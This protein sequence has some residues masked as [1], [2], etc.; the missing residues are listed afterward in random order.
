MAKRDAANSFAAMLEGLTLE[1]IRELGAR[2]IDLN[3]FDRRPRPVSRRRPRQRSPKTLT[4]RVDLV[5]ATPPIWRRVQVPSTLRLDQVHDLAQALFGWTDSH[6]HRFALGDSVWGGEAELFL[7]PY[8]VD[9]GED[10]GVPASSVRL[11]ETLAEVGDRLRYV[12][13]YGDEW[14]L[15]FTLESVVPGEGRVQVLEARGI[16]PPDDSGGIFNWNDER[17]QGHPDVAAL[18]R[19]VDAA[20]QEWALPAPVAQVLRRLLHD[21]T[22]DEIAALVQAAGC[23]EDA[24]FGADVAEAVRQYRWLLDAVGEGLALTQ[25]GYLPPR[26]VEAAMTELGL[27][28][29]WIGKGNREDM[30]P[31]VAHLRRSA[32][33]LGLL[34]VSKGKLLPTK[35]GT[36]ARTDPVQLATTVAEKAA[37]LRRTPLQREV[38]TLVLLHLAAGRPLGNDAARELIARALG[39]LGWSQRSGGAIPPWSVLR[40]D[41]DTDALVDAL[42]GSWRARTVSP[43]ARIVAR[44]VLRN[45]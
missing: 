35:A 6:L 40:I 37:A 12:Y 15:T 8:D 29:E 32:V 28:A 25:A 43:A 26:V 13:D 24:S 33:R 30:T 11:D 18:Q 9:E 20:A 39:D 14:T 27:D 31:P 23:D 2:V 34:R 22:Y 45:L 44:K 41:E 5:D 17:E 3:A 10:E 21:P 19:D 42:T 1:E 38:T 36:A 16:A 7:C 4:L